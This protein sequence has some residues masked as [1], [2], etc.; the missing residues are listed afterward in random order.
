MS[1]TVV[2]NTALHGRKS[3]CNTQTLVVINNDYNRHVNQATE[4]HVYNWS[5]LYI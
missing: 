2:S 1:H 5:Q 4:T 3:N